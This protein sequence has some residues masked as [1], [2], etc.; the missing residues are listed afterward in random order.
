VLR[1]TPEEYVKALGQTSTKVHSI[2]PG[3]K[4]TF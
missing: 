1:G 3:D 4:V 2:N